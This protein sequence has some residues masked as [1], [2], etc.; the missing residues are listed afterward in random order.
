VSIRIE[1]GD[2]DRLAADLDEAAKVAPGEARKVVQKGALNI[3]NGA[4]QRIGRPAHAPAYAS[5]ITYDTKETPGGAEAEIG[6]D[7][8][9]R[10]GALGNL[11]EY[12]SIN[13]A[14]IP[15][16]RPAVDEELP[17]FEKAMQDL[18]EKALER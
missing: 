16:I 5:S 10:Q 13:N 17:K 3:K 1:H 12:G 8:G 15:H 9:K 14:P 18:A 7:K 2:L 11:L 4:R 6:P